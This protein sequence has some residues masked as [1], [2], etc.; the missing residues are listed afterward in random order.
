MAPQCLFSVFSNSVALLFLGGLLL[1][2]SSILAQK[3][4]DVWMYDSVNIRGNQK[5]KEAY[6]LREVP[7]PAGVP[8]E[9]WVLF[10]EE[11]RNLLLNTGLFNNVW[12]YRDSIR[13]R[14]IIELTEAFYTLPVPVLELADRNFN[15][16][17]ITHN[18]SLRRL[19]YGLTF[20]HNNLTGRAD[21]L[22]STVQFGF[23]QKLQVS[24]EF[25]Y[26]GAALRW[27]P[28][29]DFLYARQAGLAVQTLEDRQVWI[30]EDGERLLERIRA[31]AGMRFR[32]QFRSFW[33]AELS[34][35][36]RS[37]DS[38]V[39]LENPKFF[40]DGQTQ[41]QFLS[42]TIGYLGEFRDRPIYPMQ[43]W[44]LETQLTVQGLLAGDDLNTTH[45]VLD[46]QY[47]EPTG[48]NSSVS[49]RLSGRYFLD[50]GS[51]LPF[52]NARGMGYGAIFPRSYEYHVIDGPN[53]ILG[54]TDFR[55]RWLSY[56]WNW[57]PLMFIEPLQ[58]MP[59]EAFINVFV[60][61]GYV[62]QPF[63]EASNDMPN[64]WILGYGIGI[65]VLAYENFLFQIQYSRGV[66]NNSGLFIHLTS[67]Y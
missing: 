19:N 12:V 33:N 6:I 36:N 25:P 21:Q 63:L 42:L 43:G 51:D 55:W 44:L 23:N 29:V 8:I 56:D 5:T 16:W 17:W 49:V 37:I 18:A 2:G 39:L 31:T 47:L 41:Q 20:Y 28:Y 62:E 22:K 11:C 53:Y 61:W 27:Q 64:E 66:H 54:K 67:S 14:L 10:R 38:L 40:K 57:G 1:N 32:P 50:G 60:D 52:Y 4:E 65:D 13:H 15:E 58:C 3:G 9:D 7:T 48:Y 59:L 46:G 26:G 30:R 34:Y 24:Y 35:F 45:L